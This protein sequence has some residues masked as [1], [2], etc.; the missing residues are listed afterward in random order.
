LNARVDVGPLKG[1]PI[2]DEPLSMVSGQSHAVAEAAHGAPGSDIGADPGAASG[3]APH[4][5]EATRVIFSARNPE[6]LP[7]A[8]V[9][10][11]AQVM[12]A[13]AV[14]L[15]LPRGDGALYVAHASGIPPEVQRTIRITPGQGIAGRVAESMQPLL[16]NGEVAGGHGRARSSILYPLVAHGRL[17]GL[18]TFNRTTEAPPFTEGDVE[19]AGMLAS[20][21]LLALENARL[22]RQSTAAEKLAAV[23]QLAA[24]IA[25]EINTPIQFIGDS[26]FFMRGALDDM[27]RLL[28]AYQAVAA[29][30]A[31]GQVV[32]EGLIEQATA[33]AE[34]VE[35]DYLG[36][37]VPRALERSLEGVRRVGEIVQAVKTF[38]RADQREKQ[39]ADVNAL[40]QTTVVVARP[41]YRQVAEVK[42]ELGE[43][44]PLQCHPGDLSQVFLNLVVNASHAIGD[45]VRGTGE[46]GSIHITTSFADGQ[47]S[48]AIA[49]TGGGIPPGIRDRVFDPF[50]TT[51]DVGKGT[52]LGLAIARTLVVDKHGGTLSF[53]SEVGRGTTFWVRLPIEA[54]P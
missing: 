47:V 22:M 44:P 18:F 14:S 34:E 23:G 32:P 7:A 12:Q 54:E 48:I 20:Q 33:L 3:R 8:I 4:F 25:H 21:V 43:L 51:K 36:A 10:A 27:A 11:A 38:G 26:L 35:I 17:Q 9:E 41:E 24:G 37:E 31:G 50:F 49:D 52:G 1:A 5:L 53:E 30:A 28:A 6:A 29:A 46:R 45:V 40:I 16:L 2:A 39:A 19:V 13:E 15:L 42:L